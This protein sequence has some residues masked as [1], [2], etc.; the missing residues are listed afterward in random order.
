[1]LLLASDSQDSAGMPSKSCS[2]TAVIPVELASSEVTSGRAGGCVSSVPNRSPER[3]ATPS[4][5]PQ[6]TH[7]NVASPTKLPAV[8]CSCCDGV[9]AAIVRLVSAGSTRAADGREGVTNMSDCRPRCADVEK[10]V[11]VLPV[12]AGAA[13]RN[14]SVVL[15]SS[16]VRMAGLRPAVLAAASGDE[17][18]VPRASNTGRATALDVVPSA[19]HAASWCVGASGDGGSGAAARMTGAGS[20]SCTCR[21]AWLLLSPMYRM[22]VLAFSATPHRALND[23]AVPNPSA[24]VAVPEPA[25][26]D[27]TTPAMLMRRRRLLL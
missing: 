8:S 2:Y 15:P 25:S 5:P 23:A 22:L 20:G 26:V 27:T 6:L 11:L 12:A 9:G 10:V 13:F 21:M 16:S 4:T 17:K 24:N 1:M 7:V 19:R 18:V 3:L 14:T